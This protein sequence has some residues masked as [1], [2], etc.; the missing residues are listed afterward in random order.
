M[1]KTFEDEDAV[2]VIFV[3]AS[4]AFNSMNGSKALHSTQIV[5]SKFSTILI[6]TSRIPARMINYDSRDILLFEVTIHSDNI[7]LLF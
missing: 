4:N 2:T 5:C 7:A 1:I 3:N 6:N